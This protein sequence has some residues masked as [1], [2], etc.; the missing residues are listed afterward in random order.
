[1]ARRALFTHLLTTLLAAS[2]ALAADA[3]VERFQ[4]DNG[5]TVI[6]RPVAGANQVACLTLF[7]IGEQHDPPKK[8]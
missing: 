1:M 4:L 7:D 5:L 6:L 3:Q 8:C 2:P